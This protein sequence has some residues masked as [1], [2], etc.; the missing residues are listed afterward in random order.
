MKHPYWADYSLSHNSAGPA[1]FS[2]EGRGYGQAS[3]K[4]RTQRSRAES[5][6]V[7]AAGSQEKKGCLVF[8][9][10]L[11]NQILHSTSPVIEA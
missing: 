2:S 8:P 1:A 10:K 9:S 7:W 11:A 6:L 5:K 4:L 3:Y